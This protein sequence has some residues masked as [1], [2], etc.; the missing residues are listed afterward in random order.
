[1][2]L[3]TLLIAFGST[4][5]LMAQT[6]RKIDILHAD[7]LKFDERIGA[8]SQRLIGNVKLFHEGTTMYCDS[9]YLFPDRTMEAF[10][11]VRAEQ[12]GKVNLKAEFIDYDGNSQ[13]AFL[14]N[15]GRVENEDFIIES[16]FLTY[17][18][19]TEIATYKNG[20]IIT[21]KENGNILI[22][23]RA[24]YITSQEQFFFADSVQLKTPEYTVYSDSLTYNAQ[25]ELGYFPN[26]VLMLSEKERIEGNRAWYYLNSDKV[27][28]AKGVRIFAENS[29][30]SADSLNYDRA[31]QTGEGFRKIELLDTLNKVKITGGYL[32]TNRDQGK[33]LVTKNA[34]LA[35]FVDNDSLF[36]SADTL[37]S[38]EDLATKQK[39]FYAYYKAGIFKTDLQGRCDSLVYSEVD[40]LVKMYYN[41]ILWSDENQIVGDFIKLKNGP[42]GAE[43][44]YVTNNGFIS[45]LAEPGLYNQI[46]G[47]N[48]TGFFSDSKLYKL[49]VEGNGETIYFPKDDPK[50]PDLEPMII[51]MNKAI[52]S[53]IEIRLAEGQVSRIKFMERPTATLHTL[54]EI[55]SMPTKLKGFKWRGDLRPNNKYDLFPKVLVTN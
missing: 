10:G 49:L 9:A 23:D 50:E 43:K 20:G 4:E 40:S 2:G 12:P 26:K 19:A 54:D 16:D 51:G 36:I 22:S 7:Q 5:N 34:L 32:F 17:N 1:L 21:N 30:I 18:L 52:C 28:F 29:E 44:L 15:Q 37:R 27:R 46:K 38:V 47:R 31:L 42:N 24:K 25:T 8:K 14:K 41:P 3:F 39:T 45:S 35:Q 13:T 6:K 48:I 53:N 33:S 55:Q 11:N